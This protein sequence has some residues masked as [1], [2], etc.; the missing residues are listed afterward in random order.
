M[1]KKFLVHDVQTIAL[2]LKLKC[3]LILIIKNYKNQYLNNVVLRS[4]LTSLWFLFLEN[5]SW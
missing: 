2:I 1:I 5:W 3:N 4:N